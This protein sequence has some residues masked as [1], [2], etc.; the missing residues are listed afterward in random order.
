MKKFIFVASVSLSLSSYAQQGT[1]PY[2]RE[3]K[4]NIA[5]KIIHVVDNSTVGAVQT[6]IGAGHVLVFAAMR[7]FTKDTYFEV[8]PAMKA[9]SANKAT[10]NEVSQIRIDSSLP[11]FNGAYSLGLFQVNPEDYVEDHE[12]GHSVQS[13]ALGPLYLPTIGLSYLME[14]HSGSFMESWA[15]L[16][17]EAAPFMNTANAK[18]GIGSTSINGV[19]TNVVIFDFSIEQ[20]QVM[21][22][23]DLKTDKMLNWVN[24]KIVKPLTSKNSPSAQPTLIEFDLVTKRL[25]VVVNNVNLY[26]GENQ[27]VKLDILAEQRY[28]H[29]ER[30][31]EL[32]RLHIKALDWATQYGFQYNLGNVLKVTPRLGVGLS[33]DMIKN[34]QAINKYAYTASASLIGSTEV[35][36]FD[37]VDIKGQYKRTYYLNGD[38]QTTMSASVGNSIRDPFGEFGFGQYLNFSAGVQDRKYTVQNKDYNSKFWNVS[39]GLKF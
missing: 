27:S 2:K 8:S 20:R 34:D 23:E 36:V 12:G 4:A 7:P 6:V 25:N 21:G 5:Q 11:W 28:V 10:G 9:Y 24:T 17:A 39:V 22:D 33:A 15:D 1:G 31:P 3:S 26:L 35:K 30:E 38:R 32:N 16:E 18:V 37:Y 19:K 29:I 14:S 13:A